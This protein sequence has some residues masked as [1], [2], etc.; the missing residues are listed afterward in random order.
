MKNSILYIV[1][2]VALLGGGAFLFLKNKKAKDASK[3]L[4][5]QT[6]TT[7]AGT[8]TTTPT[9]VNPTTGKVVPKVDEVLPVS[10]STKN[11]Q[12][13]VN[14]ASQIFDLK[15]KKTKYSIMSISEFSKTKEGREDFFINNST[16][17]KALKENVLK[18]INSQLNILNDRIVAL[19]YVEVNGSIAKLNL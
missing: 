17:L 3:L 5:L 1:G 14:V 12:E 8:P 10:S 18:S 19:G 6:A 15:N 2:A 11:A 9:T 4:D 16:M 13:A 7:G